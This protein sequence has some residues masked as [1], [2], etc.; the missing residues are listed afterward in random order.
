MTP[1]VKA[2]DRASYVPW[3]ST[4]NAV[5]TETRARYLPVTPALA[6]PT[7]HDANLKPKLKMQASR[8]AEKVTE[9]L[10]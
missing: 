4:G 5:G 2:R 10:S 9:K 3:P 7:C 6:Q 8:E 1:K